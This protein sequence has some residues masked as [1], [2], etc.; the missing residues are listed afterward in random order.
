MRRFLLAAIPFLLTP[1]TLLAASPVIQSTARSTEP[2]VKFSAEVS[3]TSP[4]R[5]NTST[6]AGVISFNDNFSIAMGLPSKTDFKVDYGN[7]VEYDLEFTNVP[8]GIRLENTLTENCNYVF[9][10]ETVY[11]YID[12]AKSGV[13][14][15]SF[16]YGLDFGFAQKLTSC[17]K[18][19]F[20]STLYRYQDP[21]LSASS[22]SVKYLLSGGKIA[23][24]HQ[25]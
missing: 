16:G 5:V 9:N 24:Q 1:L 7:S 10:V 11:T 20:L 18:I 4:S 14:G 8:L 13:S 22:S 12:N 19:L 3:M 15:H 2:A 23:Y 17:D 21:E 25:F 6:L